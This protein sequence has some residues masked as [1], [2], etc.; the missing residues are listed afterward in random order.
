MS[1]AVISPTP[2]SADVPAATNN[3]PV[4][5]WNQAWARHHPAHADSKILTSGKIDFMLLRRP[6]PRR[7]LIIP[8]LLC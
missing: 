4:S 2:T 3:K 5:G 6:K 7:G 1:R 8:F